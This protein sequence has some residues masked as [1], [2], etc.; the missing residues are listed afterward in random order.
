MKYQQYSFG[1][2]ILFHPSWMNSNKTIRFSLR[3]IKQIKDLIVKT[4][5]KAKAHFFKAYLS[6]LFA[7]S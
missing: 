2:K 4:I 7:Q 3:K 5:S 6:L 1:L